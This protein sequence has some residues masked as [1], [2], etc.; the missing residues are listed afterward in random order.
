VSK[1][2]F[3][4]SDPNRRAKVGVLAFDSNYGYRE[5]HHK[6]P[7]QCKMNA[8]DCAAPNRFYARPTWALSTIAIWS[9]AV[10]VPGCSGGS[11]GIA[12]A[13]RTPVVAPSI[14]DQPLDQSVPMGLSATFSV[15]A[16][17]SSLQ[18]QWARNGAAIAGPHQT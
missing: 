15:T 11:G 8:M 6:E 10:G 7:S 3:V 14:S 18:Y 1:P 4:R 12:S 5:P 17:G 16:T 9:V 2:G 13:P